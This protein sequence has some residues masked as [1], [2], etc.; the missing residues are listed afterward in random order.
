ME[1]FEVG[2]CVRDEIMGLPSKDIDFTVVL[3]DTDDQEGWMIRPGQG[4]V[5]LTPFQI[6]E[7]RLKQEGFKIFQSKPEFSTIRAMFPKGHQHSGVADFVL[8]RIDGPSTDGRRPDWTKPGTLMDDLARRDFTMNAIA[9]AADGTLIDPFGGQEDIAR[10]RIRAVGST[11]DRLREDA[12]RGLR[13]LRFAVTKGFFIDHEIT[14]VLGQNWFA[15]A[16]SSVSKERQREEMEKMF[17]H[18]TVASLFLIHQFPAV[19]SVVFSQGL[20]L[21]ATMKA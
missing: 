9:K 6:M 15:E 16:L 5:M 3:I 14:W 8:A 17:A 10:K 11:E 1:F 18:D 19:M 4:N 21:S 2:G 20:R 13:A 12:L 7:Q